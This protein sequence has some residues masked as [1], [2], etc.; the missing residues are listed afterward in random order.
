[1]PVRPV[2]VALLRVGRRHVDVGAAGAA[3]GE[4]P[5]LFRIDVDQQRA[6][7]TPGC[8]ASAPVKPSS[9]LTVK[10]AFRGPCASVSSRSS[11]M[12]MATPMPSSA[13]SVVPSVRT[14]PAST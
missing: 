12:M 4:C 9:S 13:P 2:G 1:M 11:A 14:Q 7:R 8:T 10:S 3:D 5:F 6:L